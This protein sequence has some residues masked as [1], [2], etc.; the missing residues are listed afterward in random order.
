VAASGEEK[1]SDDWKLKKTKMSRNKIGVP[2]TLNLQRI[3]ATR[4]HVLGRFL[5]VE[6]RRAVVGI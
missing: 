4:L 1:Q 2:A 5:P 6:Q 3:R